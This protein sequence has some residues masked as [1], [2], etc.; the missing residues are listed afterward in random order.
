M[1]FLPPRITKEHKGKA[2]GRCNIFALDIEVECAII[3]LKID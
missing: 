3:I 2:E 1:N